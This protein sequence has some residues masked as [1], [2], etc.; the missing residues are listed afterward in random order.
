MPISRQL[1]AFSQAVR[2]VSLAL[3]VPFAGKVS[4]AQ[5]HTHS[6]G[7]SFTERDLEMERALK[8]EG[9][10]FFPKALVTGE[11]EISEDPEGFLKEARK[12]LVMILD[13]IDGTG[14]YIRG[15]DNYAH[16]AA[17]IHHGETEAGVIYTP[18]HGI[19][20]AK[21]K[22]FPQ[23]DIMV[24][25]ERG[26]GCYVSSNPVYF[27]GISPSLKD[28]ARVAFACH[29]QDADQEEILGHGLSGHMKRKNAGGDYTNLLQDAIDAVFY[30]EGFMPET[31][32]G[33]CPPWDHAAGILA[34]R[35]AGGYAALPYG[36]VG[37]G[38]V[39][40]NPL[41]CHDRILVAA[42]RALFD[43][44]HAHIAARN[45]LLTAPRIHAAGPR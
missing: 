22:I 25:A 21:G 40:Y 7:S 12:H 30:S 38:G 24:I 4:K 37:A 43:E 16:M 15:D 41:E 26:Q 44:M 5:T 39:R 14:A 27:N 3:A 29:N 45:P 34:V 42:S 18:G 8:A 35:E 11:E 19:V 1:I 13:P 17:L 9:I 6:D 20:D 32:L 33:K 31:N 36:A 10:K 28:H 2:D 23:K